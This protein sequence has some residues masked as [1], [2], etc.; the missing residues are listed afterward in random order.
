MILDDRLSIRIAWETN[1]VGPI[2]QRGLIVLKKHVQR[3]IGYPFYSAQ[4]LSLAP[5]K[6][7]YKNTH[8]RDPKTGRK[9]KILNTGAD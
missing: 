9:P 6:L 7:L 2:M 3:C 1:T 8:L 5:G 4:M